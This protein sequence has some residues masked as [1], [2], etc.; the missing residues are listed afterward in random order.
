LIAIA[1]FVTT[2]PKLTGLANYPFEICV[3]STFA[4]ITYSKAVLTAEDILNALA[5]P[6]TTDVDKVARRNF[7]S[8]QALTILNSILPDN[9]LMHGQLNTEALW[10]Y[11]WTFIETP[12]LVSVF[13]DYQ[14]TVIFQISSN[15]DPAL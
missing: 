4:L 14:R 2:L 15:Q 12:G 11:L 8:F 3:K 5:L 10:T 9:L 1:N 7:L 6:Q 13:A